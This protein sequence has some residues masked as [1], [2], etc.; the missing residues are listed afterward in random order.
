MVPAAD[1]DTGVELASN[2]LDASGDRR[3]SRL[4]AWRERLRDVPEGWC[5]SNT[6][7]DHGEEKPATVLA[8]LEPSSEVTFIDP[9]VDRERVD[10]GSD[11][12]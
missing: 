6:C 10:R 1:G 3:P 12:P 5:G 4:S 7:R 2:L 8:E 9:I 11:D